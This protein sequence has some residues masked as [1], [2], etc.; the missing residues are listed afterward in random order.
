LGK[1]L[2]KSLQALLGRQINKTAQKFPVFNPGI[3]QLMS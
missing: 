3:P 2:F 1:I